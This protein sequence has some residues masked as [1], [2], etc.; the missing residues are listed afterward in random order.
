MPMSSSQ[1]ANFLIPYYNKTWIDQQ[2][3]FKPMF[4]TNF[5]VETSE[6][7]YE[8]MTFAAGLGLPSALNEGAAVTMDTLKSGYTTSFTHARYGTGATVSEVVLSDD[9]TGLLKGAIPTEIARVMNLYPDYMAANVLNRMFNTAYTGGDGQ[10]LVSASHPLVKGGTTRNQLS[11]LA[12]LTDT[13]LKQAKIDSK[14]QV[15]HAGKRI[16]FEY[17]NLVVPPELEFQARQL[18]GSMHT[19]QATV[20]TADGA[21]TSTSTRPGGTIMGDNTIKNA[22]NLQVHPY[23]TSSTQWFLQNDQHKLYFFWRQKPTYQAWTEQLT[24]NL[25]SKSVMRFSM[26]WADFYGVFGGNS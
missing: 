21:V 20:T 18:M 24:G 6:K 4:P 10:P 7:A 9:Q 26:N 12:V 25:L 13:S 16:V 11:T 17:T 8:L 1:F 2:E 14:R 22:Y 5:H 23:L 3:L 15:D 19:Q